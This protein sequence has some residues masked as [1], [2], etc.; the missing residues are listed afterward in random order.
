MPE[1]IRLKKIAARAALMAQSGQYN[2][3]RCMEHKEVG[4]AS[5][6]LADFVKNTALIIYLLNRKHAPFYKWMFRGLKDLDILS[7]TIPDLEWIINCENNYV[8][9]ADISYNIEKISSLI[10][11]ELKNQELSFGDWDYLE[12]HAYEVMKRI[13][14]EE[15]RN[16]H[17]MEGGSL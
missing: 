14:A 15:I 13:K 2:Y 12:P 8:N 6:A 3:K 7:E 11:Q 9:F 5:L 16:M 17:V 1:D 10:I 4:A